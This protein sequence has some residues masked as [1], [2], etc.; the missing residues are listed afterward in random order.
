MKKLILIA[1]AVIAALGAAPAPAAE[2]GV[3]LLLA[4]GVEDAAIEIALSSDGRSYVIDS[5]APLEVGAEICANPPE[6][7]TELVCG[8]AAISGFE[9][10]AGGGNDSVIV[11]REVPVP[12][13]LRGGAGDDNLVGGAAGDSLLGGAG[14]DRLV[15]RAGADSLLGGEGNDRL[16]GC[17]GNDLLRGGPGEDVLLGGSGANDGAQ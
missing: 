3:T 8:A 6:M 15:G 2:K 16:V 13:T 14:N 1:A 11:A 9:V 17:S 10:N 7:P 4:G 12:V 5:L